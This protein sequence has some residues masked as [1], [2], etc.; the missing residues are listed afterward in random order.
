MFV[1]VETFLVAVYTLIDDLYQAHLAPV[2][3][4]RRGRRPALSDSEVLTLL[5]LGQWLGNSERGLL[6]HAQAY[7]RS[8][9]PRLLS[10]SA[11]NRRAR[12]LGSTC[13]GLLPLVACELG[14]P[15]AAY[16]VADTV[17]VPLAMLCRGKHHRLFAEDAAIG[18]G[19]SDKHFYYGQAL[20]LAVAP[21][22]V[23]SGFVAGPASTEGR[24]LLDALLTWRQ[25]P[26]ARPW[27]AEDVPTPRSRGYVGPTG[28]RWWPG[29]V[30]TP[31]RV[32]YIA[33]DGFDGVDWIAHWHDDLAATV[34][35][36]RQY[37]ADADL[38]VRRHHRWRQII[39]TVNDILNTA[40]HLPFPRAKT[41]WG[42]STRLTAKCIAFNIGIWVNR[43]LGRADLAI[44][45]LFPG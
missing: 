29:T 22:G 23:I 27:T 1:D 42:L 44:A 20:L 36:C 5:V 16:Q 7:W 38:V 17:P 21:D 45:T 3:P 12:D 25:D 30:G 32:P 24:W 11:F 41:P 18:R 26:Q 14:A 6:R 19:G 10:Q 13:A 43:L 15:R 4:R 37:G 33:D 40:L 39:E 9:F 31:S 35:T 28:P 8:Y 34:L 2:K